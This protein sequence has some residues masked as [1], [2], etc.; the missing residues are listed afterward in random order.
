MTTI[1]KILTDVPGKPGRFWGE[2]TICV[3][4]T[5]PPKWLCRLVGNAF[6]HDIT[7]SIAAIRL[8]NQRSTASAVVTD[9]GASGLLFSW[10]QRL[11]PWGRKRHVMVDC[12]W[13][14]G[15]SGW[16]T[17]L[18]GLRLRL[19][20]PAVSR[21]VVW[22]SH[23]EKDYARVFRL[24]RYKLTY[25]PFHTTLQ[26]YTYVVGDNG[27]L[28]A[29]GNFD[30]D[31]QTLVEAV[32]HLNIPTWIATTR[33]EQLHGT[34]LPSHVRIEGTSHQGFRQAMAACKLNVIAMKPGLLH[35]GGQQTCLNSMYLGK[36][37]IAVGRKW[38]Q[39]LI[40]NGQDGLIVDYGDV[41]GLQRAIQW[42]LD[43]PSAAQ[44]MGGKAHEKARWFT[45]ERT[46]RTVYELA[47]GNALAASQE[48][49]TNACIA[50]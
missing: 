34:K 46:M 48:E 20:E 41:T 47:I 17:W 3:G 18:K 25:V 39:D 24:P 36:P 5:Q 11:I 38:A 49:S 42:V 27:Y 31:Y 45:T 7:G 8:F 28:F 16:K 30:R 21:F 9:G 6:A 26:D 43:N 22:A 35:S 33:P 15:S 10:L 4:P 14:E 40:S 1:N 2:H 13:Y 44:A 37:T 50:S 23:E 29:G 32:R 19:A 12:N